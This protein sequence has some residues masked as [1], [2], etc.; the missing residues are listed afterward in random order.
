VGKARADRR[1]EDVLAAVH[2]EA[3]LAHG[4]V[5]ATVSAI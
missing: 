1:V 2:G 5:T 4:E 3:Q